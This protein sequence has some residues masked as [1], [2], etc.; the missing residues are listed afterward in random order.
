MIEPTRR[1]VAIL[2]AVVVVVLVAA[3]TFVHGR[4]TTRARIDDLREELFRARASADSCRTSLRR[5]EGRFDAFE[6]RVDSLRGRVEGF[7]EV[8]P[9]TG[10]RGV[11]ADSYE[12]Y[13]EAYERYNRTIPAWEER[14][15]SLEARWERCRAVVRRHNA[16]ADSLRALLVEHGLVEDT[17]PR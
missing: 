2:S 9:E 8:H 3:A 7:E 10:G 6:E 12:T 4:L 15:D 11:P 14:A 13:M 5:E 1:N 17:L 16:L